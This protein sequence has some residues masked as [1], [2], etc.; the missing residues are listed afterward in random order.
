MAGQ[1]CDARRSTD[2]GLGGF[3]PPGGDLRGDDSDR[4]N[5]DHFYEFCEGTIRTAL[6]FRPIQQADRE[7]CCQDIWVELLST[8]MSKFR[9][10]NLRSWLAALARNKA[11]DLVR[12]GRRHPVGLV[13]DAEVGTPGDHDGPCPA[14][15][16][17]AVVWSTL[18]TLEP[19]VEPRSF[20]VFFLRW[21]EGWSFVEIADALD[22]TPGQARSRHHRTKERFRQL[23]EGRI[24]GRARDDS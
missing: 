6:A 4:W 22:L 19:H 12:R 16:A 9:G 10:G 23:V 20:L 5:W 1:S 17:R 13:F 3:S 15:E 18:A 24:A 8:R 7:D 21:I 11:I 14:D 2:M